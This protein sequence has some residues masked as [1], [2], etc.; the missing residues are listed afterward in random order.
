MQIGG[1]NTNVIFDSTRGGGHTLWTM[2][3]TTGPPIVTPI[4][5]GLVGAGDKSDTQPVFSPDGNYITY[6]E[7]VMRD[8]TQ[9]M[10]YELSKLGMPNNDETDLTLTTGTP[11]N[12]QP[13]W[14]PTLAAQTPEAPMA[15]LLP[16]GGLVLIGTMF[17]VRRRRSRSV[18]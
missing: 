16:A 14:Q 8:A 4:W 12:S 13:D 10:D 9:V 1:H 5:S 3:L 2:D 7:P 18:G 17:G 15:V 6:T 11:A